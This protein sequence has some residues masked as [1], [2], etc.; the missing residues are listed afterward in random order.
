MNIT[1][2][3]I[4]RLLRDTM[5]K[6]CFVASFIRS[7]EEDMGCATACISADGVLTCNPKFIEEHVSGP[8]ECFCLIMHEIMHPMFGHFIH[9]T[10]PLE[11][12]AADMIINACISTLFPV[13][14]G[15]GALFKS[16]Y[17]P[18]G[19]EGLLR[20]ESR[21]HDS[22]YAHLY[23]AVYPHKCGGAKLSTGEAIR[24]LKVLSP[25]LETPTLLL[26]NHPPQHGESTSSSLVDMPPDTMAKLAEDLRTAV[27]NAG[28]Q[29]AGC[30]QQLHDLLIETISTHLSLR[31]HLLR[32]YTTRRKVDRFKTEVQ[33]RGSVITPV[34]VHPSKR[35]FVLLAAGVP[36]FHY[37]NQVQRVTTKE[38]GLAIYLDV[39]G[40]VN[41][42][43][44]R[45]L[46]ALTSLK[47]D[48]NTI[49]MFSNSVVEVSMK[50]LLDGGIRTTY[51]TDFNCVAHSII[52][53]DYD[54]AVVIT[55]GYAEL[56]DALQHELKRRG[57][58]ILTILFDGAT[59]CKEF[60]PLGDVVQLNDVME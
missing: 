41:E 46:S 32:G 31:R 47:H 34:P 13:Q 27:L 29:S 50:T 55:D 49:F 15:G 17:P 54:K 20:P 38:Q 51:G 48:L 24:A 22:R 43:L 36:P 26:G 30:S 28:S 60:A 23:R 44:P 35:D 12:L 53:N 37:R 57:V 2:E 52:A 8:K 9:G 56:N 18:R 6:D 11:N 25:P 16:V 1:L 39:S 33:T 42:Y 19:I 7:V 4:R 59:E 45:I 5:G 3:S 14:S 10:G 21:M 40:S 58:R